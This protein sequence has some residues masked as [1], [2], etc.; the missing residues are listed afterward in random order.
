M[1]SAYATLGKSAKK[2]QILQM[3]KKNYESNPYF[4]KQRVPNAPNTSNVSIILMTKIILQDMS[5]K[6]RHKKIQ[7]FFL[8][9]ELSLEGQVEGKKELNIQGSLWVL[10]WLLELLLAPRDI[11]QGKKK[12]NSNSTP[13]LLLHPSFF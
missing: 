13:F 7:H 5:C 9:N 6:S 10:V 1:E 12:T 11:W 2:F 3:H 4:C 8:K